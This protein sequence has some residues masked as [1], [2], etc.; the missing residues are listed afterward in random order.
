VF[1]LPSC[2]QKRFAFFENYS[3]T[4]STDYIYLTKKQEYKLKRFDV[5]SIQ[6]TSTNEK[7]SEILDK[8]N[9]NKMQDIQQNQQNQLLTGYTITDSGYVYVPYLGDIF[10]LGLSIP[11]LNSKLQAKVNQ[12][13]KDT[14]IQARMNGIKITF[15][16]EV[17]VQGI[18]YF[19]YDEIHLIDAIASVGGISDFGNRQK[20]IIFRKVDTGMSS[21][22]LDITDRNILSSADFYLQPNDIVYIPPVKTKIAR[23]GIAEISFFLTSITSLVTTLIL[24]LKF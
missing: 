10:V 16:G 13:F 23:A 7:I 22:E 6:F 4:L 12:I 15:I 17:S 1:S 8:L 19:N 11:E 9:S 18:H 14:R 24:I 2:L 20:V 3:D 5:L 21:F